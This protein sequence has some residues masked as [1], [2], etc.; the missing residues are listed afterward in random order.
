MVR[1][2]FDRCTNVVTAPSV[3]RRVPVPVPRGRRRVRGRSAPPSVPLGVMPTRRERDGT[4]WV[5][6]CESCKAQ[7]MKKSPAATHIKSCVRK[8]RAEVRTASAGRPRRGAVEPTA[9][10]FARLEAE[11]LELGHTLT[12][13]GESIWARCQDCG[14]GQGVGSLS[15]PRLSRLANHRHPGVR[16]A[17]PDERR[18][19]LDL[20]ER[21]TALPAAQLRPTRY[22][23]EADG[24]RL[25]WST[26][27]ERLHR[28]R[29]L[30]FK[31]PPCV[32]G[33]LQEA[34]VAGEVERC[35]AEATP[36][37]VFDSGE[38]D[39]CR[40][41]NRF[42]RRLKS[43]TTSRDYPLLQAATLLLEAYLA[44]VGILGC[45]TLVRGAAACPR[46]AAAAR[47]ATSA[48]APLTLPLPP[49]AHR[50]PAHR[51]L[52]HS[53][54]PTGERGRA[55]Q[56]SSVARGQRVSRG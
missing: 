12:R 23:T 27:I 31:L 46:R 42:L 4:R 35:A 45:T 6:V 14:L 22:V 54:D 50:R 39:P 53:P 34:V 19:P 37:L 24:T 43:G 48:T 40:S 20:P 10:K 18:P 13:S 30:V 7:F 29:H 2:L 1:L 28:E 26:A 16:H 21:Q 33:K 8:K 49:A 47:A 55:E 56:R 17:A 25:F 52:C 9:A 51:G 11:A 5:W 36:L 3:P 44:S 15:H 32:V 41:S 38:P